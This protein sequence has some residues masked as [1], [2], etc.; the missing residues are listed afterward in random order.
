MKKTPKLEHLFLFLL[1]LQFLVNLIGALGP[2]L[3]FDAL[4][5]HLTEAKLFLTN[6][7]IK[8]IPGNLL[9]WS[10]LPRL[11][12]MIYA[13]ALTIW[14]ERL[15]KLIHL[16]F[17]CL[18]AFK[19]YQLTKKQYNKLS[20]LAAAVLFYTTLLIGWLST[21]SYVDLILVALLL[22]ALAAKSSA[23]RVLI[24]I[25]AGAV[26]IQALAIGLSITLIPWSLLGVLP[27]ALLN[28][29]ST[30]NFFYPFLENFG[31]ET[32]YFFNGF[33][34]WFTRPLRLFFDFNFRVGPILLIV[35]L[36]SFFNTKRK[37]FFLTTIIT[38]FVWWLGPGTDFGRFALFLLA[39]LSVQAGSVYS[40]KKIPQVLTFLIFFQAILGISGRLYAN[41]K[42]I[43]FLLG[44]QT[45]NQFLVQNLKF[46]FGDWVDADGW[47]KQNIKPTDKVLVYN[48]HN[49]YYLN[50]PYDHHTWADPLFSYT[51]VL[52]GD[53]AKLP[54]KYG[55]PPLIYQNPTT[56]VKLYKL[57]D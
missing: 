30:G 9:Y 23:T 17:G 37:P 20:G 4:W 53:N 13:L 51:H 22:T 40:L 57:N 35:F 31:F 5:Y 28:Y 24:L 43:P 21:V 12:E 27:F 54:E 16:S 14:D 33:V 26:K 3:S 36:Y 41:S 46:H 15:T 7:S 19:V 1:L 42:Y 44:R 50:F 29:F 2:E 10:G 48:I 38:F 56:R 34:F 8:P 32:E 49:L 25:L 55:N 18:A 6:Q 52:M 39:L 45:K 11:G 47:F